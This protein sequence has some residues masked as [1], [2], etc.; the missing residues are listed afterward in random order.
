MAS[1][2]CSMKPMSSGPFGDAGRVQGKKIMSVLHTPLHPKVLLRENNTVV[3]HSVNYWRVR[4]LPCE[5]RPVY[6]LGPRY[7]ESPLLPPPTYYFRIS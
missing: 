2:P 7:S 5:L 1:T 4:R 6:D 3:T